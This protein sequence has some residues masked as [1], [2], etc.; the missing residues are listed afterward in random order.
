MQ[1]FDLIIWS[2]CILISASILSELGIQDWIATNIFRKEPKGDLKKKV[3]ELEE[4]I[5]RL[6]NSQQETGNP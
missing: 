3:E 1:P 5:D 2:I 4:R 6:E